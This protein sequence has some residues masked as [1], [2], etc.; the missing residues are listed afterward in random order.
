MDSRFDPSLENHPE[1]LYVTPY[2]KLN[3]KEI[4]LS[5]FFYVELNHEEDYG[6]LVNYAKE[7]N[8]EIVGNDKYMPLWYV[9]S[10]SKKSNGNAME[11][12][13]KFH[14][15][16]KFKNAQPDLMEDLLANCV[17]DTFFNEQWHL[18]N[19][20]QSGGKVGS[21]IKICEAWQITTMSRTFLQVSL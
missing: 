18:K 10:C 12:A 16:K 2:F 7:N 20:G 11:M 6:L 8:V 15:T 9:L 19:T 14:E 17:D 4:G 1:I 3:D 21:D 5:H 13:N